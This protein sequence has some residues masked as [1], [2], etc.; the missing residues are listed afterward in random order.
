MTKEIKIGS[1]R[2]NS[3]SG[4]QLEYIKWHGVPDNIEYQRKKLKRSFYDRDYDKVI[5]L[6]FQSGAGG[7][8]LA[9]CLSLSISVCSSFVHLNEKIELLNKYL[10]SQGTF[11]NDLYL[12]NYYPELF[13]EQPEEGVWHTTDGYFFVHEHEGKNIPLHLDFW[14]NASMIYFKNTDLF[15][16]IRKLLKNID[17]KAGYI[18][19]E[20]LLPNKEEYPIPHSFSEFFNLSTKE[21]DDLKNAYRSADL[22]SSS[23]LKNKKPLYVWDT[24]WYFS[25]EDTVTHIKELYDL[26]GFKDFNEKI[27]TSYYRKWISTL[28]ELSKTAIPKMLNID[29]LLKDKQN[30]DVAI[31][32]FKDITKK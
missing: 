17:G 3:N 7:L 8:F 6:F 5:I 26:F 1:H 20:P 15:C 19:Y 9:N 10:N 16:K 28:D 27:I 14:N 18:S 24:N 21:Q 31:S 2:W 32:N 13:L 12:N 25:E 22:Y 23:F 29:E 11:W 30:Y 4:R